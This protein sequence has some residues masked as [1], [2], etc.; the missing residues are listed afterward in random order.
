MNSATC[1]LCNEAAM[2]ERE[3]N[4]YSRDG[5]IHYYKFVCLNEDCSLEQ[6]RIVL[7][8]RVFEGDK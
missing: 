5:L 4:L 2:F 8:A 6:F 3:G 7:K 1:P